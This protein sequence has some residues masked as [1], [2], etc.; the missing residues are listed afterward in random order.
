MAKYGFNE[1]EIVATKTVQIDKDGFHRIADGSNSGDSESSENIKVKDFIG[2][3]IFPDDAINIDPT[4][5]CYVSKNFD[6]GASQSEKE[7][8]IA[9]NPINTAK[10]L[11]NV[12]GTT[13]DENLAS[14]HNII[15][16]P[17]HII[18]GESLYINGQLYS[19]HTAVDAATD[20]VHQ[21]LN[22]TV[23]ENNDMIEKIMSDDDQSYHY[24][25]DISFF[26]TCDGIIL[27]AD[28][29]SVVTPEQYT[30]SEIGM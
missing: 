19:T 5:T 24:E 12:V 14:E 29:E 4:I 23:L 26:M 15:P 21:K 16:S 10:A 9:I 3:L 20:S 11:D 1:N 13:I 30:S 7:L 22:F 8:F 17:F 2:G 27:G 6:W 25:F 18:G 28:A